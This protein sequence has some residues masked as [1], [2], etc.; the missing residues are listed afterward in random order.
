MDITAN[1][2]TIPEGA[3]VLYLNKPATVMAVALHDCICISMDSNR[4][5]NDGMFV[6]HVSEVTLM[7]EGA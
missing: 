5:G 4:R 6:V 7:E 1:T 2:N 3:R